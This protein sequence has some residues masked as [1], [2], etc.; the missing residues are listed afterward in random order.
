MTFGLWTIYGVDF[1]I[2]WLSNWLDIRS[3]RLVE[4]LAVC[5]EVPVDEDREL[6][7]YQVV[8]SKHEPIRWQL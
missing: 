6:A 3:Y 7:F 1:V 8:R 4:F 5:D 2:V